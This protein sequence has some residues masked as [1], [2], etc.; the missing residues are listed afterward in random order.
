MM[1]KRFSR[2]GLL[3]SGDSRTVLLILCDDEDLDVA[4]YAYEFP[5]G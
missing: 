5:L 3:P 1:K 2:W 4:S